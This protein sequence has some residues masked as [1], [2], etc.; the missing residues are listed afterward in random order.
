[1]CRLIGIPSSWAADPQPVVVARRERQPGGRH[2]PDGDAAQAA[3]AAPL[4]LGDSSVDVVAGDH[5]E[6]DQPVRRRRA[7]VDDPVVV[8]PGAHALELGIV[9]AEQPQTPR[10]EDHLC[11]DVALRHLGEAQVLVDGRRVDE[12]VRAAAAERRRLFTERVG[13]LALPQSL[14]FHHVR[15]RRDEDLVGA[16]R[17][18]S[19]DAERPPLDL[20]E[21]R[22]ARGDAH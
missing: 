16:H 3:I 20:V 12:V 18:R 4:Q 1:M 13:D 15:V 22:A 8:D 19:L 2:L 6:T 9:E 7:V 11:A 5:S 21:H 10:R 17:F 14:R